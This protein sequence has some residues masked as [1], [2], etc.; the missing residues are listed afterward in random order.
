L[1][2][3]VSGKGSKESDDEC[4]TTNRRWEPHPRRDLSARRGLPPFDGLFSI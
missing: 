3:D 2:V 4:E 1:C